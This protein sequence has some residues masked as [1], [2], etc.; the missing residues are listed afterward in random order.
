M[1]FGTDSNDLIEYITRELIESYYS[2]EELMEYFGIPLESSS[3]SNPFREDNNPSCTCYWYN[4]NLYFKDWTKYFYGT[5][6]EVAGLYFG[7]MTVESS[8]RSI[9]TYHKILEAT[10]NALIRNKELTPKR[11]IV[12]QKSYKEEIRVSVSIREWNKVDNEFWNPIDI[13]IRNH[14]NIYP[15]NHIFYNGIV[16]HHLTSTQSNPTY[17]YRVKRLGYSDWVIYKPFDKENK[18]KKRNI[19]ISEIQGIDVNDISLDDKP[20]I[21]TKSLKD[22]I[23]LRLAT[24]VITYTYQNEL[25]MPD[26]LLPNTKWVIYDND[27]TGQRQSNL[28][29]DKFNVANIK[30]Q[31]GKDAFEIAKKIGLNELTEQWNE[32]DN[33]KD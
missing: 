4:D 24:G 14:Y 1:R 10:Y 23:I 12:Q 13:P 22:A 27:E 2:Q 26:E 9:E 5:W 25:Y 15:I 3:F 11:Q 33:S 31:G 20:K 19:K 30:L 32:K 7:F 17:G 28:I 6:V 21:L 8:Y 18:W 16:Q 29:K